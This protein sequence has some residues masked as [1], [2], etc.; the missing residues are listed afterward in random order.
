MMIL[1]CFSPPTHSHSCHPLPQVT[2]AALSLEDYR[3]ALK[4]A[5]EAV[6]SHQMGTQLKCLL[7][8]S[9]M[10]RSEH[11]TKDIASG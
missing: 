1:L 11:A 3:S 2:C 5:E 10:A 7:L 8:Q 6:L 9:K 4:A